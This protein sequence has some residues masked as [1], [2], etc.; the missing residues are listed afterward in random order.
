MEKI[1]MKIIGLSQTSATSDS[2]IVVLEDMME[3]RKIPIVVKEAEA[4]FIA[5]N[6][7]AIKTS[8]IFV[9]DLIKKIS[10]KYAF[11]IDEIFVHSVYE[12]IFYT[13]MITS[14]AGDTIDM[15]LSV[16]DA[17][18]LSVT[19]GCPI[20][21]SEEVW[22]KFGIRINEDGSV[23]TPKKKEKYKPVVTL[24]S[25]EKMLQK[26]IDNEEYEIASQIR[27]KIKTMKGELD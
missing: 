19:Q 3:D 6:H 23:V 10:R 17:L 26:A 20:M 18:C 16:G 5:L 8:K 25:L 15:S 27:D 7:E 22:T 12:G 14:S 2:Y 1:E 24:E 11:T 13:K 21:V 9:W 4:Q